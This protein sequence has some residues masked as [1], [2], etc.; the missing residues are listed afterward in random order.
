MRHANETYDGKGRFTPIG[1]WARDRKPP[2]PGALGPERGRT[3]RRPGRPRLDRTR[4]ATRAVGRGLTGGLRLIGRAVGE[5]ALVVTSLATL[6]AAAWT[7]S[8]AAGLVVAG[9]CLLVL[10]WRIK[11]S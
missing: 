7:V 1:V 8:R 6:T 4:R 5:Y 2:T 3:P 11:G 9:V 10:E